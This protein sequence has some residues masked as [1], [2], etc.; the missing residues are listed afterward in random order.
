MS[1]SLAA[2]LDKAVQPKEA[3]PCFPATASGKPKAAK[4][5]GQ[6]PRGS[7]E[8][9]Q[10]APVAE[11]KAAEE[12]KEH[13]VLAAVGG[14]LSEAHAFAQ[15][16]GEEY[17]YG[18]V[19]CGLLLQTAK[20][21]V[22]RGR[23]EKWF[24]AQGFGFSRVTRC[25]YMSAA[26][27]ALETD[28]CKP[29]LLLQVRRADN[30]GSMSILFDE[31]RLKNLVA[32]VCQ[33]KTLSDIYADGK[34]TRKHDSKNSSAGKHGRPRHR[35]FRRWVGF[36]AQVPQVFVNLELSQRKEVLG[37]LQKLVADLQAAEDQTN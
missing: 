24:R 7:E 21:V 33:G 4:E 30:D 3:T 18:A 13:G 2:E 34:V 5:L 14:A 32:Q 20:S 1:V 22:G 26:V 10:A 6:A 17:V 29:S 27:L 9:C 36:F 11:A 25:K 16:L 15:R 23:F 37:Q 35:A 19:K 8:P 12:S 28:Q 31:V